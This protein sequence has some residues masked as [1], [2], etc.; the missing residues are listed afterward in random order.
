[1]WELRTCCSLRLGTDGVTVRF[2]ERGSQIDLVLDFISVW[3]CQISKR[4]GAT[5]TAIASR[6]ES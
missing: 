1:M 5:T 3:L 6:C 2:A 4:P